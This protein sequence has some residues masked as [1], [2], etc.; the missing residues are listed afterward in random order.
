[1]RQGHREPSAGE[2]W[3]PWEEHHRGAEERRGHREACQEPAERRE[4]GE[5][6]ELH[7]QRHERPEEWGRQED[8]EQPERREGAGRTVDGERREP[9]E[10]ARRPASHKRWCGR[11]AAE[12]RKAARPGLWQGG[13]RP[14]AAG[15]WEAGWAQW[16]CWLPAQWSPD[17]SCSWSTEV[18]Q[19]E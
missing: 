1:M 5:P 17:P 8:G 10:Q 19:K 12:R 18:R 2:P 4:D 7:H 13:Q 14:E 15:S 6:Q 11:Q 3:E 16:P 9:Q